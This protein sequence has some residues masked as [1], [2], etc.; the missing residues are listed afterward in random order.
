MVLGETVFIES[1]GLPIFP[2]S[3][4][5]FLCAI[6]ILSNNNAVVDLPLVPVIVI[7]GF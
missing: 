2:I 4:A 1:I 3:L 7:L 5:F 6:S